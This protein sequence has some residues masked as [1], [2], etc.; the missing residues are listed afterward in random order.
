VTY[1]DFATGTAVEHVFHDLARRVGRV[2]RVAINF[3]L[4]AIKK[5]L[6]FLGV[7]SAW[8]HEQ[9]AGLVELQ[10]PALIRRALTT[11]YRR[12][13]IEQNLA[14]LIAAAP[15]E[16]VMGAAEVELVHLGKRFAKNM[17]ITGGAVRALNKVR[18]WLFHVAPPHS[19]I[20]VT[21]AYVVATGFAV[22]AGGDYLD[23]IPID[24][25]PGVQTIVR[26]AT[27]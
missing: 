20:A 6:G 11:L 4:N 12:D 19:H 9:V 1:F 13:H 23:A 18:R 8:A 15:T 26:D 3:V 17:E 16:Q 25:V 27:T 22:S 14:H 7:D 21:T 5:L 2:R 10:I 24:F